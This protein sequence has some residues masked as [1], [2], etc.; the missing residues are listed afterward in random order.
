MSNHMGYP[1][2]EILVKAL[3]TYTSTKV[4]KSISII[5]GMIRMSIGAMCEKSKLSLKEVK[6]LEERDRDAFFMDAMV[7]FFEKMNLDSNTRKKMKYDFL[8]IYERWKESIRKNME[9][10]DPEKAES[11]KSSPPP[12]DTINESVPESDESFELIDNLD[13]LDDFDI[14]NK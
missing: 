14:F 7:Y 12:A 11:L 4:S 8:Q 2:Q 10:A 1:D 9:D 13:S 5:R 6:P 3:A